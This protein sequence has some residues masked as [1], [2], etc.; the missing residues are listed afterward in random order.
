MAW[1]KVD[2]GLDTHEKVEETSLAA[3]G[4]WVRAGSYAARHLTDG[5]VPHRWFRKR[6]PRRRERERLIAELVRE[7]R[8]VSED[9]GFRLNDYL[10]YNPSREQVEA[11]RARERDKKAR[12]RAKQRQSTI[13]WRPPEDSPG[14]SP[15]ASP[16]E[17]PSTRPVPSRPPKSGGGGSKAKRGR[18]PPP[19]T[20]PAVASEVAP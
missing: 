13:P 3:T 11:E 14:D 6:V 2:D 18:K 16:Q 15:G 4:L 19:A 7:R 10:D 1:F 9:G 20:D 12:G 8:L 5:F 17:S